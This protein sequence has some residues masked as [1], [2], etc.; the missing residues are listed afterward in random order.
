MKFFSHLP[1]LVSQKSID[2][3]VMPLKA[4]TASSGISRKELAA[5]AHDAIRTAYQGGR[6]PGNVMPAGL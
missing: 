2:V 6:E 4:I 1:R 5:L 3:E